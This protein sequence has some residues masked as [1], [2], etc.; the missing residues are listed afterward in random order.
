MKSDKIILLAAALILLVSSNCNHCQSIGTIFTS[1]K[2][3][4]LY[5]SVISAV[6]ISK[7]SLLEILNK[8]NDYVMLNIVEE[9]A[10]FLD[11][12][13]NVISGHKISI[14]ESDVFYKCSKSKIIELIDLV[15]SL[16]LSIEIRADSLTISNNNYTLEELFPCPP[17]C[18]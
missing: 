13:R 8:T 10:V 16:N 11:Q 4:E 17:Y 18:E 15:N 5:G 2:A 3:E 1:V 6:E 14:K 12:S 9:K 7:D